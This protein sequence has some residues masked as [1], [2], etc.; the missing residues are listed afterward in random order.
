MEI[1]NNN[2]AVEKELATAYYKKDRQK[3]TIMSI[4]IGMSVLLLYAAFAIADGKVRSDYLTDIRGMGTTANVSLQNGSK[5]QYEQ[6]QKL[7]YLDAVGIEKDAM[8]V[9]TAD[10]IR[11]ELVYVD[12]TAF[13]KMLAP[14]YTDI[15]GEYPENVDE[16]MASETVL[17]QYGITDPKIG[18]DVDMELEMPDGT[19]VKRQFKVSGFYR[20]Y[21]DISIN[22]PK[23]YVSEAFLQESDISLFPADKIIARQGTVE[24]GAQIEQWVYSDIDM[25]YDSQQVYGENPMIM[26]KINGTFGSLPVAVS[27]VVIV[28]LCAF[29]LIY[30]VS[31]IAMARDIR[32]YGMLKVIGTTNR[33]IKRIAFRNNMK[34]T[35]RGICVG[36][37]VGGIAVKI[38]VPYVLQ[39]LYMRG[40]GKSDVTGFYAGYMIFSAFIVFITSFIAESAAVRQV[41]KKS[42]IEAIRYTV[43]DKTIS[44]RNKRKISRKTND[45]ISLSGIAWRNVT[46]SKRKLA[47][48]MISILIGM[49]M[50]LGSNVIM[51][52]TD[53]TNELEQ[54][55]D[56]EVGIL[57][58]VFRYPDKI[59][60]E[61]NDDTPV[62]TDEMI[63]DILSINGIDADTIDK[64]C[65]SY[66][67]IRTDQ[68]E[69][70]APRLESI[71]EDAGT[72][73]F[74][75]LQIVDDVYVER[76]AQYV[77][78]EKLT[79]DIDAF[80][81]G[82]GCI[83][84]HHHEMS[85]ILQQKADDEIGNPIHF[86]SLEASANSKFDYLDQQNI[87]D[88]GKG[89]LNCCGYLDFTDENFPKLQ[90]T[91]M[92][93]NINYFIMTKKAFNK[94]GF[95]AKTFDISFDSVKNKD[96]G[97]NQKLSQIVQNENEKSADM[98]TY[99]LN[100]NYL[101]LDSEKS[102]IN[103]ARLMLGA[104]VFV[105]SMIGMMNYANTLISEYASRKCELA[106]MQSIG[107]D[108]RQL[109]K[110]VFLEGCFYSMIAII[111]LILAGSPA[112]CGLGA[113]I[114]KKLV[115]FKFIYPWKLLIVLSLMLFIINLI[116]AV[117]M[118]RKSQ[119]FTK[120]RGNYE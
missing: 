12:E 88:Y 112:I 57:T 1:H 73:S 17:E 102:R 43:A 80:R 113:A 63:D 92:G 14:A 107:L 19:K 77:K 28:V 83:L 72:S 35:L 114:R 96:T 85:Q 67:V 62:M 36:A 29:M 106:V 52:G 104:L 32:Q 11:Q 47:V 27:C 45:S 23:I 3:N 6:M 79:A 9:Y 41:T 89:S 13:D 37:A 4:A 78:A 34:N 115:Y 111:G 70:L 119:D 46:R 117:V 108:R 71:G 95:S 82:E 48:S 24:S 25:E 76:L 58:G 93:N 110:M 87:Q 97:I 51:T 94:L 68:D 50:A 30:N 10:G 26:Q 86:Y 100:A 66:A 56:F 116:I 39:V 8:N 81:R 60:Q 90:T 40:L 61:I 59:P 15:Y 99:Y 20:D 18:Q 109:W 2:G 42:A 16:I 31:S 75:T 69:A 101:L 53:I 98:D 91:S 49:I 74:A 21:I 54:N 33:Q 44:K 22:V 7:S 65:G 38:F 120:I 118:Y 5:K 105:I 103:T 64:T 84:L 55:P